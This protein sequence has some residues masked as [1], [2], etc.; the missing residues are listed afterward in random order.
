M[1]KVDVIREEAKKFFLGA[2]GSHNFDHTERVYNLAVRIAEKEGA[3]METVKL[4][5]LLHDIARPEQD[6]T[7]GGI[8]HAKR[9]AELAKALLEKHGFSG[10]KAS[11][12]LHC[13]ESH[14]FRGDIEPKTLEARVISDADKLDSVGAVGIGRAFL[15]AGEVG[16]KLHNDG[17]GDEYSENDTAY[18]EFCM[19]LSKI[20]QRMLTEEGRRLAEE[21]HDF[22]AGFFDRFK[23]E[24]EGDA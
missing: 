16:A 6:R 19:K 14:R 23:R 2:S 11:N 8:C 17:S 10:E 9:G 7:R 18:R 15:F 12:V 24:I 21:R 22:M 5:A 1:E 20:R 13:I 3:D 4:A